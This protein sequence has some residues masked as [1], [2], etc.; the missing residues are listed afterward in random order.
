M[1]QILQ[2]P[3]VAKRKGYTDSIVFLNVF[4][5]NFLRGK[6]LLLGGFVVYV[7]LCNFAPK[8]TGRHLYYLLQPTS[9]WGV[10]GTRSNIKVTVPL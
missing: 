2:I 4:P 3:S 7:Q 6:F 8:K 9:A 5:L 10:S 1:P